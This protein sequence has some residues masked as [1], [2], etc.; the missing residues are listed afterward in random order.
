MASSG[1]KRLAA[2]I[3]CYR[4]ILADPYFI[5]LS[6]KLHSAAAH[7]VVQVLLDEIPYTN[8]RGNFA[9]GTFDL[10]CLYN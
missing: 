10:L 4:T 6:S 3:L 7:W 8:D 5:D 9:P 1:M 2:H